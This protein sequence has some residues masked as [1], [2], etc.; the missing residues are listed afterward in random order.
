L[1]GW[2]GDVLVRRGFNE[3][4]V[5]KGILSVAFLT[6]LLLIPAAQA[7]SPKV[8]LALI[9]G[10]CLVGFS[11]ANQLVILQSC[12]S[13]TQIGLWV[14]IF[15]FVG[16]LAGIAAP[17]LT[18]FIIAETHSYT[19]AFVL[20]ALMIAAGQFSFWFAAHLEQN[21]VRLQIM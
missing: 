10:G 21:T 4:L 14:G 5:R 6:G 17:K 9:M 16:N 12:A 19:P 7:S 15:N 8:A 20:A 11:T 13:P 3:T 18:G 2:L 1:G